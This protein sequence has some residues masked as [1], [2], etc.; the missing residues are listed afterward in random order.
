MI[1][2]ERDRKNPVSSTR[3]ELLNTWAER[4]PHDGLNSLNTTLSGVIKYKTHLRLLIKTNPQKELEV[5][6][7]KV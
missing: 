3:L 4:Q 5:V 2:H 6:P 7:E 1:K